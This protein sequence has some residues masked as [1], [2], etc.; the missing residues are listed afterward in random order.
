MHCA[1]TSTSKMSDGTFRKARQTQP[2]IYRFARARDGDGWMHVDLHG[3][4]AYAR[5]FAA[6]EPFYNGQ[7]R[8]E[9]F[10]GGLEVINEQGQSLI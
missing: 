3:S 8:V 7:A 1:V 10:D 6:V 5:R 9:R 4:P 2:L